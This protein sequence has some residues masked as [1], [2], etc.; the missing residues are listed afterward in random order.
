MGKVVSP[1]CYGRKNET[2]SHAR[3]PTSCLQVDQCI[4]HSHGYIF[5]TR[6]ILRSYQ[7]VCNWI[8]NHIRHLE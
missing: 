3:S 7:T 8:T 4:F 6:K 5:E 1:N 2:G